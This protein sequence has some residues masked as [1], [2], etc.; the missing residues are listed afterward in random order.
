VRTLARA[1]AIRPGARRSAAPNADTAQEQCSG[2]PELRQSSRPSLA[3]P[4]AALAEESL[5]RLANERSTRGVTA[6][7]D[8]PT[9]C[10]TGQTQQKSA[11]GGQQVAL[12]MTCISYAS[13]FFGWRHVILHNHVVEAMAS[14]TR[15]VEAM[16]SGSEK[17][18]FS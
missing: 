10:T 16:A 5:S 8:P 9:T 11:D 14:R 7:C 12:S 4:A 1:K 17:R 2:A 3:R 13:R 15:P 6:P 18:N